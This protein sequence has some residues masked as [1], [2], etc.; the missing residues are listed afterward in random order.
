MSQPNALV[1]VVA[2][3]VTFEVRSFRVSEGISQ[4][5]EVEIEAVSQRADIDLEDIVGF[6]AA[7][8]LAVAEETRDASGCDCADGYR[9]WGGICSEA[10]HVSTADNGLSIYRL[11]IEPMLWR[12]TQRHSR[13]IFQN[14][15]ESEIVSLLLRE[16]ELEPR[17]D[18]RD[19]PAAPAEYR[20]QLDESDYSFI[21][22]QL[23]ACGISFLLNYKTRK[24]EDTVAAED[25]HIARMEL[26]LSDTP[27]TSRRRETALHYV[28]NSTDQT[29]QKAW[30]TQLRLGRQARPGHVSLR[31]Y[32]YR[33]GRALKLSVQARTGNSAEQRHESYRYD[34]NA[35]FRARG[36]DDK[37]GQRMAQVQLEAQRSA[38]RRVRMRSNVIDLP[39]GTVFSVHGH[40]RSEL[41]TEGGLL[42][43]AACIR[44]ELN[45]D[46][47]IELEAVPLT[48]KQRAYCPPLGT[49]K[50]RVMGVQSAVVVGPRGQEIH[51]D[52]H[53]RIKVQFHWDRLGA[54]DDKSSCWIRVSQAWA[55]NGYGMMQ[56]PRVGEEVVVGFYDG[57]PDRPVVVGRVHNREQAFPTALPRGKTKTVWRSR[58]TPDGEG[59]NELSFEDAIGAEVVHLRAERDLQKTVLANELHAVGGRQETTVRGDTLRK[60]GGSQQLEVAGDRAMDVAGSFA[61]SAKGGVSLAS[62]RVGISVDDGRIVI[63]NGTASIVMDGPHI[64]VDAEANIHLRAGS[65]TKVS[66]ATVEVD[67]NVKVDE[68]EPY[69]PRVMPFAAVKAKKVRSDDAVQAPRAG[70]AV[71]RPRTETVERPGAMSEPELKSR[72]LYGKLRK[73]LDKLPPGF[74]LPAAVDEQ[75]EQAANVAMKGEKV[76]IQL[77][78]PETYE[79]MRK[80]AED[81]LEAERR[82]VEA[83]GREAHGIFEKH[84]DHVEG[85]GEELE[86]RVAREKGVFEGF[87]EDWEAIWNGDHGGFIDSA[88]AVGKA[89]KEQ[90]KHVLQLKRDVLA[91]IARERAWVTAAVREWKGYGEKVKGYVDS[92]VELVKNPKDAILD[93]LFGEDKQLAKDIASL[94]EEFGFGDEAA[95]LFNLGSGAGGATPDPSVAGGLGEKMSRVTQ[96]G[97]INGGVDIG[98]AKRARVTDLGLIHGGLDNKALTGGSSVSARTGA[99]KGALSL[100]Q[101]QAG[102]E[103]LRNKVQTSGGVLVD[104]S[105]YAG[106]APSMPAA[107]Q[108]AHHGAEQSAGGITSGSLSR[109]GSVAAKDVEQALQHGPLGFLQSPHDGQMMVVR[110]AGTKVDTAALQQA[111]VQAQMDGVPANQ[112]MAQ[113]LEKQ[114]HAVYQRPWGDWSGPLSRAA[115]SAAAE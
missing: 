30:V 60:V 66:G 50:P 82:R 13:R 53:G 85:L 8:R 86:A 62:G 5:F 26:L 101:Q 33:A 64:Y 99:G 83:L 94:A 57:D 75:L 4:L 104:K 39:P 37:H 20:V 29:N 68:T 48:A 36:S 74:Q 72:E 25:I 10:E 52:E 34:P 49:P 113:A 27:E 106:S 47:E 32:D 84:R 63:S 108:L 73:G 7:L 110:S 69:P 114:G 90:V 112:A 58:S 56:L 46:W 95:D 79:A 100:G 97:I 67:A 81:K 91:M 88:K 35:F 51:T 38:A 14:A 21:C 22:R 2:Q 12:T 31:G 107:N 87:G 44:G 28:G 9:V 71:V 98:P 76:Y 78:D 105:K 45:K 23:E 92:M 3:D 41:A 55:G 6:G 96:W 54:G 18:L 1:D 16:W 65:L 24:K 61:A 103:G 11:R 17:V 43:V 42:L 102:P 80:R 15:T 93:V 109:P 70:E 40:P 77:A 115:A 59:Y 111:A 89:L 19:V